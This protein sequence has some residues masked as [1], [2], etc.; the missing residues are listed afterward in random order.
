M[1]VVVIGSGPNSLAAA[2]Y[3]AKAGL[4]PIVLERADHVGGGA[5]TREIAPGFWCPTRSHEV[6]AHT[7]IVRDMKLGDHGLEMLTGEVIACAP[8]PDGP[9]VVLHTDRRQIVSRE[10]VGGRYVL[11]VEV[12]GDQLRACLQELLEPIDG[13][14]EEPGGGEVVQVADVGPEPGF[15]ARGKATGVLEQRPACERRA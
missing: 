13:L 15:V 11:R 1:S 12:V 5:V 4:K 7:R 2:W 10:R 9:P 8:A 6:L 14:L 3:L